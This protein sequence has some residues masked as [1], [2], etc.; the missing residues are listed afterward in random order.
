MH[1]H[2]KHLFNLP[3]DSIYLNAAYMTPNLKAVAEAGMN[4]I[5]RLNDP[6]RFSVIDFFDPAD[7][8]RRLFSSL[9]DCPDPA[10]ICI[11]PSV[12]YGMANCARNIPC[13]PG[14]EILIASE[15]F[16][17]HYYP[18]E[19]LAKTSGASIRVVQRYGRKN[20]PSTWTQHILDQIGQQTKIVALP[21]VHWSYGTVFDLMAIRDAIS[22]H[23][24]WLIIDGTQSVGALPFSVSQVRP[25]ALICGGYKWLLGPY[26]IGVAYYGPRFDGGTPIEQSW[27]NRENSHDF[28]RLVDYNPNYRPKARRYEVGESASFIYLKMMVAALQ[29]IKEWTPVAIQAYCREISKDFFVNLAEAGYVVEKPESRCHHLFGVRLEDDK[30]MDGLRMALKASGISVSIRGHAIRISPHVYNTSDDLDQLAEVLKN[31]SK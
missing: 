16:P 17:S 4:E 18:W 19:E 22:A 10:R 13:Q 21:V 2:Q 9:V 5:E 7:E 29:Q 26:G 23:E 31:A 27:M 6:T 15:Q 30:K 11:V 8:V 12:S 3:E 20:S 24:G 1:T 25:D 28:P 14:D